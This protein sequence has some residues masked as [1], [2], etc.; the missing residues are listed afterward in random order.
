[1]EG[2]VKFLLNVA[3]KDDVLK[4]VYRVDGSL[5]TPETVHE[6]WQG[7]KQEG[8]VRS[9]NQASEHIQN[10]VYGEMILT[11]TPIFLDER[12]Q[13]LR[14]PEHERLLLRLASSCERN[15]SKS[16]AGLWE[17]RNG[18]QEHSFSN[19]MCWAGL[20]RVE[21]MSK[22]GTLSAIDADLETRVS[23]ARVL[24][25]DS[26]AK[27]IVDGALRNGPNDPSLDSALLQ[28]AILGYPDKQ[29]CERTIREIGKCLR[30]S[31]KE[32][33]RAFFFRYLRHD[34]LGVPAAAFVSCSFW[35]AQA[36]AKLGHK[37]EAREIMAEV[38][39]AAN[40]L[41]LFSEHYHPPFKQQL[42]NFPQAFSHVGLI[43]AAFMVSSPWHEIL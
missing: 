14:T 1:M 39:E 15:I 19:L 17:V 18:W 34:D 5:P 36:L 16:D 42:G 25:L 30:H 35:Y 13:H 22:R 27:A 2:F 7:Y 28:L 12:F 38:L 43:N 3:E 6:S 41:G 20:E 26:L 8:P 40:P 10:D 23:K 9:N 4:P 24:A 32:R 11:L 33:S 31:K 29:V 37:D 21:R